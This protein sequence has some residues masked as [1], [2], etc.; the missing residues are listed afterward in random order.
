MKYLNWKSNIKFFTIIIPYV[1]MTYW[2]LWPYTPIVIH[3][4]DIMNKDKIVYI[5]EE[6]V[7]E[8]NYIK[9]KSYPVVK[10]TR[11]LISTDGTNTVIVL[12]KGKDSRLPIGNN[13]VRVSVLISDKICPKNYIFH[14]TAEYQVNFFRTET[15]I[16]ESG[17]FTIEKKE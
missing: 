9:N 12:P 4:I 7:Y 8:T 17:E 15:V 6:L 5:G 14:L 11:Q 1:L 16:A 2:L 13:K 10:V 3:N